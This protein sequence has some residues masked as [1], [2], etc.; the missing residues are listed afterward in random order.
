MVSGKLFAATGGVRLDELAARRQ[1]SNRWGH[2]ILCCD[3]R[4]QGATRPHRRVV[5]RCIAGG[6]RRADTVFKKLYASFGVQTLSQG[7]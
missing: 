5:V 1:A 3:D 6:Q 4:M 7:R 2:R